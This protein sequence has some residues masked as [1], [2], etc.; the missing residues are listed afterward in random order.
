MRPYAALC[1]TAEF[2]VPRKSAPNT[3][4]YRALLE[5]ERRQLVRAETDR[6]GAAQHLVAE[7]NSKVDRRRRAVALQQ[8]RD[9]LETP[10]AA[11]LGQKREALLIVGRHQRIEL[12]GQ[13]LDRFI[14][15]DVDE[16]PAAP[17][18]RSLARLVETIGVIRDLQRRLAARA[19]LALADRI[20]GVAL[21]FLDQPHA[22]HAGLAVAEHFRVAF[23]HARDHAAARVAQRAHARLPRRDAGDELLFR[24]EPDDLVLGIAAR[25]ERGGGAGDRGQLDEV[26]GDPWRSVV[27]GQAVVRRLL[28]T[29]GSSRR[30]PCPC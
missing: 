15:R 30:T 11:R 7:N 18:A 5:I 19:Q 20:L 3:S 2:Q 21:E 24:N 28:L 1:A 25:G 27:A 22:N 8:L 10:A 4:T 29:C 17:L 9:Q 6:V 16:L 26:C 12:T 23:H 13:F 14:P